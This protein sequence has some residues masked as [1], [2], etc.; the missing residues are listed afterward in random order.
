MKLTPLLFTLLPFLS[1]NAQKQNPPVII[2]GQFT[3][4]QGIVTIQ[5]V[6][7]DHNMFVDSIKVDPNGKFHYQTSRIDRPQTGFIQALDAGNFDLLLAP[8]YHLYVTGDASDEKPLN[9]TLKITGTG[10]QS[11]RYFIILDS[12]D[13]E[14]LLGKSWINLPEEKYLDFV[15]KEYALH[16]TAWRYVFANKD[17][18]DSWFE[19]FKK[20]LSLDR[21]FAKLYKLVVHT[22]WKNYN[23]DSSVSFVADNFPKDILDNIYSRDYM[24][25]E[26]YT[27]LMK[28]DWIDY[29]VR[30]DTLRDP[31][32]QN[33]PDYTLKKIAETFKGPI[34]DEALF[35][36]MKF[37]VVL[38]T[39]VKSIQKLKDQY[40]PYISALTNAD[41]RK[42]MLAL[43]DSQVKEWAEFDAGKPAPSFH[44]SSQNEKKYKLEDFRNKVVYIDLWASWC[45]P[46]REETPALKKLY[47]KYKNDD[48]IA[49]VS[50]AVRDKQKA[51]LKA[52][53]E[54][55]P[56]WIQLIDEND[57]VGRSYKV[58]FVP[59]FILIDKQGKIV[60]FD[61]PSPS[62]EKEITELL[63]REIGK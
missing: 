57:N 40:Q 27:R 8:G 48:R 38:R 29:L 58:K 20:M 25:S 49:F 54:D 21:E 42:T 3:H 13:Q 6:D 17:P 2:E 37:E 47:E 15:N 30:L 14:K 31:E 22:Y 16:E 34:K 52:I 32:L 36:Q 56:A 28:S 7:R 1:I 63:E 5:L 23:R 9:K 33:I 50:I 41:Y 62:D 44:L 61:A 46:C 4:F 53:S 19:D 24:I 45:G 18:K 51:W 55:K 12:L 35:A 39:S 59:R 43:F 26:R 11:N 60:D 10:S